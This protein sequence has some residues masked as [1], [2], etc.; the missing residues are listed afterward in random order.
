MIVDQRQR[1]A[2][3][4]RSAL[5][6]Q[7]GPGSGKTRTLVA[8]ALHELSGL[9]GSTYRLACITMSRTAAAVIGD[10]L[11]RYAS[12]EDQARLLIGTIHAFCMREI[13]EPMH[14][15]I[16]PYLNGWALITQEEDRYRDIVREV[17]GVDDAKTLEGLRYAR[18][19]ADGLPEN[20]K[21]V[22]KRT[23]VEFWEK[24]EA[25]SLIDFPSLLF[26]SL[27]ILSDNPQYTEFLSSV[28]RW[29]L[30]DEF[31]DT[32]DLQLRIL[33]RLDSRLSKFFVVG[34]DNQAISS[35]AGASRKSQDAFLDQVGISRRYRLRLNYRSTIRLCN[36]ANV[37]LPTGTK[38]KSDV[39]GP[40]PSVRHCEA[41]SHEKLAAQ[42][43]KH[44]IEV[45]DASGIGR[46]NTAIVAPWRRMAFDLRAALYARGIKSRL[47]PGWRE[48]EPLIKC[49]RAIAEYLFQKSAEAH[50]MVATTVSELLE[51]GV[52]S[53]WEFDRLGRETLGY[54]LLDLMSDLSLGRKTFGDAISRLA[55][56]LTERARQR[57]MVPSCWDEAKAEMRR[58]REIYASRWDRCLVTE[59]FRLYL[60]D[61]LVSWI[62]QV[63]GLEFDSVA[64]V[65]VND[66]YLPQYREDSD[67]EEYRRNFFVGATRPKSI[68]QLY[69]DRENASPYVR[70]LLDSE[71]L[72]RA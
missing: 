19:A 45:N 41:A 4:C 68:L 47:Y 52:P 46:C 11:L 6:V 57:E 40:M 26:R 70:E 37:I 55:D 30:I 72:A 43:V 51:I 25:D 3:R 59:K 33:G 5:H 34:D 23:V 10:R 13:F 1:R 18:R 7:A 61:V 60:P 50:K 65:E 15:L 49:L 54:E 42:L 27:Q 53:G 14:K 20:V 38:S 67:P 48:T 44:F 64:L 29:I 39:Q 31:Q 32:T 69:A 12:E 62:Y 56:A 2:V 35:F 63:K 58:I 28:Y 22:S 21:Y 71:V 9:R 36:V 16:P 17:F 8:K 24:L 66:G